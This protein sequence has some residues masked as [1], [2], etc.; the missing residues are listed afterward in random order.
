[1]AVNHSEDVTY[2]LDPNNEDDG[3]SI[4]NGPQCATLSQSLPPEQQLIPLTCA[5]PRYIAKK[6]GRSSPKAS[7]PKRRRT[8]SQDSPATQ[9]AL[10]SLEMFM[11]SPVVE[12]TSSDTHSQ[13]TASMSPQT[14]SVNQT[15]HSQPTNM[16]DSPQQT[17]SQIS[18][19]S[20]K[21]LLS[22]LPTSQISGYSKKNLHPFT[23]LTQ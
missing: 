5:S 4:S 7:P 21:S 1:M 17:P 15:A 12:S 9:K 23:V 11:Q 13:L 10:A 18:P 14:V 2:D 20:V 3:F 16:S 8:A 22:T 6:R 19:N